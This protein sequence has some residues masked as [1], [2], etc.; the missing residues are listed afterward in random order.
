[1]YIPGERGRLVQKGEIY[2]LYKAETS[3]IK[4]TGI[5]NSP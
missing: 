5:K 2:I 4:R 1:M 3:K